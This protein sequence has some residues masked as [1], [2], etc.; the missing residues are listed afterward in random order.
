MRTIWGDFFL[1]SHAQPA[2]MTNKIRIPGV[3][4]ARHDGTL[5]KFASDC[6]VARAGG[7]LVASSQKTGTGVPLRLGT[8]GQNKAQPGVLLAEP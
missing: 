7:L 6:R 1:N 8:V 3:L 4:P 2:L 5:E